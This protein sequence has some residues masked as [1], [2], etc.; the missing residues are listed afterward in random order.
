MQPVMHLIRVTLQYYKVLLLSGI[1]TAD[2]RPLC[3][4][5]DL[6]ESGHNEKEKKSRRKVSDGRINRKMSRPA[7][8]IVKAVITVGPDSGLV[9]QRKE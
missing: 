5:P 9:A 4:L 2:R 1:V 3:A 6:L 7:I 8:V